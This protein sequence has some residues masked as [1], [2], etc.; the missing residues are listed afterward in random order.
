M[1]HFQMVIIIPY[2]FLPYL[3]FWAQSFEGRIYTNPC[4]VKPLRSG[5][6]KRLQCPRW[7]LS[8]SGPLCC[9]S[10]LGETLL[11]EAPYMVVQTLWIQIK[12]Q[13]QIPILFKVISILNNIKSATKVYFWFKISN[14]LRQ[15]YFSTLKSILCLQ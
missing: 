11:P 14:Q 9:H 7:L 13:S 3:T 8:C 5:K 2:K 12:M 15:C 6:H 4:Q 10:G 1:L